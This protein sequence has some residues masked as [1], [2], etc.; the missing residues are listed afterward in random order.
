MLHGLDD[1]ILNKLGRCRGRLLICDVDDGA[2]DVLLLPGR[3][4][5]SLKYIVD[6]IQDLTGFWISQLLHKVT[7]GQRFLA[8]GESGDG[9]H[10]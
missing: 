1:I 7:R 2:K 8:H 3:N 4:F 6:G 9:R 10:G 5:I